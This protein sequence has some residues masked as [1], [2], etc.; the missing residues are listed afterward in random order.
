[1]IIRNMFKSDINRDINGVIKMNTSNE[2]VLKQELEEYVVTKELR[3]HF[4]NFYDRYEESL[5]VPTEK[6]GVWISGF[7]GSGKSHFLKMLSF[8]LSNKVV[9]GKP[10][11]E[12]FRDKFDDPMTFAVIERC[13]NVPTDTILFDIDSIGSI[14][15][16]KTVIMRIFAKVFYD[17]QGFYGD[18][19]KVAKLEK[20]LAKRGK[21]EEFKKKFEEL[22]GDSWA[23]SRDA[24]SFYEDD[25]VEALVDIGM[26]SENAARNW[27]NGVETNELS[28]DQLTDEIKEYVFSKG[29]DYR[30]IFMID[31]VGQYIGS[32]V[33]LMLNLQS[34]VQDLGVK[35][36]G[37]VW[38]MVTSQEDVDSIVKVIG[39]DFSKIQGRFDTRLSLSSSSVDEVIKKRILAKED[40]AT[41]LLKM[42]Y[43]NNAAV[44]KNLYTFKDS[45]LDIKGYTGENDFAETFPFV[46]YQAIIAQKSLTEI[47]KHGNAG[48]HFADS[49]RPMLAIYKD[50]AMAI[51]NRDENALVPFYLFYD[52]INTFLED[53]IRRVVARCQ[54]AADEHNGVEQFD[55]NVLKLLYLIRYIDD[56]KPNIENITILMIDDVRTDKITLKSQVSDSLNRLFSQ[57]Y[58]ARNGDSY[59]FLT[60]EEQD[61]A[62]EIRATMIDSAQITSSI[63]STIFN[64]LYPNKKYRYQNKYDFD[65]DKIVD[66]S[67]QSAP[68]GGMK[69]RIITQASDMYNA[70]E[71][72]WRMRTQADGEAYIVLSD[73][74][75]YFEEIESAMKIRKYVKTRNVSQLPSTIQAIIAAKQR[76]ASSYENEAKGLISKSFLNAT[77]VVNGEKIDPKG[78]TVKDKMDYVLS[79]LTESVYKK[80]DLI[81]FNYS[82]DDQIYDIINPKNAGM[83]TAASANEEAVKEISDYL[84]M[85]QDRFLPTS[86]KDIQSRFSGTGYGWR[87][88]D[89]AACVAELIAADEISLQYGGST[90][91][92][93]D[94]HI[95]DYL[96]K[97]TEVDKV[98][99]IKKTR[100]SDKILK[101]ARNL[102]KDYLNVMTV[103][104][105]EDELCKYIIDTFEE[106]RNYCD[107]LLR[108]Y[109]SQSYPGKK[110]VEDSK[111]L[112]SEIINASKDNTVLLNTLL[113]KENDLYDLAD[114]FDN[115]NTFFK[116]QK[117]VY[118]KGRSLIDNL[119]NEKDFVNS[120][121][122]TEAFDR[123]SQILNMDVPYRF[124]SEIPGLI[125]TC[126]KIYNAKLDDKRL[127]SKRIIRSLL[128]EVAQ[129]KNEKNASLFNKYQSFFK[130]KE[131]SVDMINLITILDATTSSLYNAKEKYIEELIK[132]GSKDEEEDKQVKIVRK[133]NLLTSRQLTKADVDSYI[134]T[135]RDQ[136][137][138]ELEDADVIQII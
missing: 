59:T 50:A 38:V 103:P 89:I 98:K 29:K 11:I 104:S 76:Q 54:R 17:H 34:I 30:L 119:K 77:F 115:V 111:A 107:N 123:I 37:R 45:V 47:R 109:A 80:L 36:D 79:Y 62:R 12:Y 133:A 90:L 5:D 105:K 82:N 65:F 125:Q 129:Y 10:T 1:M 99:V 114:D 23:E 46:P 4:V 122:F 102:M 3:R 135:L 92:K 101:D 42:V 6:I 18:D 95:V 63:G 128:G 84:K 71:S 96:R 15:K 70:G 69:V 43:S 66:E 41:D 121:E 116:N 113:K 94:K 24:F 81:K 86:M 134:Q 33:S 28:I 61:I 112:Y 117:Q 136:L 97:K 106:R 19:L 124:I 53:A 13:A 85:Q 48:K 26:F 130:S 74:Y 78:S 132:E 131:V 126:E 52:P 31:E 2:K 91:S 40:N 110:V 60:D 73:E 8:L 138:K 49:A 25:V 22:H 64:D 93:F 9:A 56:F 67:Y 75:P 32:D 35:C 58:V 7:F 88:I 127:E 51:Q 14:E 21:Y 55:V 87:E 27:F 57:N 120:R 100:V 137:Y 118:D 72:T 83:V 68:T 16:N 108:N 20:Q 39:N 44:L